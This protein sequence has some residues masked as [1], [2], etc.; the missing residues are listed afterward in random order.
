MQKLDD[1]F[2]PEVGLRLTAGAPRPAS[3]PK[4]KVPAAKVHYP[5][6]LSGRNVRYDFYVSH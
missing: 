6:D 5:A 3:P 2:V 1:T 4:T